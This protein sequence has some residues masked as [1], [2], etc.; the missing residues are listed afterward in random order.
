VQRG[1]ELLR[2]QALQ[3]NPDE[4]LLY[5]ELAWFYQHKMGADLDDA[6]MY[7]KA[8]WAGEMDRVLGG[9]NY[10]AL[11]NPH[12]DEER[13]RARVLRDRYKLEPKTMLEIDQEYGPLEWRLPE[14]HSVYW[15]TLGFQKSKKK[16]LMTLRRAIFQT[17]QLMFQRGRLIQL[18]TG[19]GT[20]IIFGPNLAM[21]PRADRTYLRMA[22][23]AEPE[24]HEHI[25]RAHRNFLKD[26]RRAEA[27]TWYN[28]LLERYPD[29]LF[30]DARKSKL[31]NTRMAD[32]TVDEYAAAKITE[33][34]G[35][36]S[37]VRMRSNLEG[38]LVTS[39]FYLAN[40]LDDEALGHDRLAQVA[41]ARYQREI[42]RPGQQ[43]R[44]KLPPLETLKQEALNV[45]RAT[46]HPELIARL[47]TRLGL[48]LPSTNA[49]LV[50][51]SPPDEPLRTAP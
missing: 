12:T 5:R 37:N 1:I 21:L 16:D 14:A 30:S 38:L 23:E 8:A 50:D 22:E 18:P 40:D 39:F 44:I 51:P 45:F 49:P 25:L 42:D 20:R 17:L 47:Y 7:Y 6:H 29:A 2:D 48:P 11:I 10:A 32:I 31:D 28:Y 19:E 33:D 35:E 9:T 27:E 4:P 36:T 26:N 46:Y 43:V 13:A 24:N 15:A 34:I 41:W 3:Y